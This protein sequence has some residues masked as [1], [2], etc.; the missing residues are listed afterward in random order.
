VKT[1]DFYL[2]CGYGDIL[3]VWYSGTVM[4]GCAGDL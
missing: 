1:K 4:V 3:G 2:S